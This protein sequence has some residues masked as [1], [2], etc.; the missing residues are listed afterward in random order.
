MLSQHATAFALCSLALGLVAC[1]GAAAEEVD[2]EEAKLDVQ[3]LADNSTYFSVRQD[4]RRCGAP[5]CGGSFVARVNRSTTRCADGADGSECYV[6]ELAFAKLGFTPV[7]K[8]QLLAE[9]ETLLLRGSIGSR[10]VAG[11][12]SVGVLDVTEVWRGH[13]GITPS[14]TFN[15]V[16]ASEGC[17]ARPCPALLS[18]G[19]LN[20][21]VS[22]RLSSLDLSQVP[23]ALLGSEAYLS[24]PDGLMV[25][26][27]SASPAGASLEARPTL[28]VTE[29]YVPATAQRP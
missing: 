20:S 16:T 24:E 2:L 18:S 21:S 22:G 12:G 10:L 7:E 13:A 15:R 17:F 25:T 27:F 26:G 5:L 29:Y 4:F 8:R 1:G 23:A 6:A 14:G 9:P 19:R 28:Y 3:S 11:A